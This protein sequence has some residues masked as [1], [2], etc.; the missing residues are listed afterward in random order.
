MNSSSKTDGSKEPGRGH[1]GRR[2]RHGKRCLLA[3]AD[4]LLVSGLFQRLGDHLADGHHLLH[5]RHLRASVGGK[6]GHEV[7]RGGPASQLHRGLA[8]LDVPEGRRVALPHLVGG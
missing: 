8:A 4:D 1:E 2:R 5:G 6:G 7:A 3:L